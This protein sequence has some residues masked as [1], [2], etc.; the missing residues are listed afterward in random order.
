M[1]SL[2]H[3]VSVSQ[4][5]EGEGERREKTRKAT[6]TRTTTVQLFHLHRLALTVSNIAATFLVWLLVFISRFLESNHSNARTCKHCSFERRS[7][8]HSVKGG[9]R[10]MKKEEDMMKQEKKM[11]GEKQGKNVSLGINRKRRKEERKQR[12]RESLTGSIA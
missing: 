2:H 11:G 3:Y 4:Q 6:F 9:R 1:A 7:F 8:H 10:R 12:E 5:E